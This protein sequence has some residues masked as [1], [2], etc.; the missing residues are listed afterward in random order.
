MIAFPNAKINIGLNVI[1]KRPD[2]FHNIESIFF[3]ILDVK[4]ILEIVENFDSSDVVFSSSGIT[5]PGNKNENLCL[6]AYHLIKNDFDIPPVKIHLHKI[7]PIGA[8]LG[9]GSSDAAFTLKILNQ[10]FHL[11][12]SQKKLLEY[13]R[14]L[15]SDCA[16]FIVNKPIYA[17][18]KG[19]EFYDVELNLNNYK[20]LV[21]YPSIHIS[22]A[23]AYA[24]ITPKK[25]RYSILELIKN[26]IESWKNNI[27]NDF[28]KSILK[29]FPEIEESKIKMYQNGAIYASMTGSGSAVF[30]IFDNKSNPKD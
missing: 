18:N 9:G 5:I 4:D 24:G 8:G 26:P 13:A 2:G 3:P 11:E 23:D 20:I 25:P 17:F 21:D 10:L 7:I 19:D 28:E 6:K 1:E 27:F 14:Q 30:G 12:I 29:K 15:G 22:T 16:F